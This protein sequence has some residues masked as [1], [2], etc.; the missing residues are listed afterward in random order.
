MTEK[1]LYMK[2]KMATQLIFGLF[3]LVMLNA[4]VGITSKLVHDTDADQKDGMSGMK[5]QIPFF[6]KATN[7]TSV[8]S[9][10]W[11]NR[12]YSTGDELT[13][14]FHSNRAGGQGTYDIWMSKRK[15]IDEPWDEPVNIGGP[16]NSEYEEFAVCVTPDN[17]NL[18]FSSDRPGGLG[19]YDIWLS[20]RQ[21]ENENWEDPINLG[22]MIN[23]EYNEIGPTIS[24]DGLELYFS[25]YSYT[26]PRPGTCGQEDIWVSTRTSKNAQWE[27]AKN[28]GPEVNSK[29]VDFNP[30]LSQ[31]GLLLFFVSQRDDHPGNMDIWYTCRAAT[32][33]KWKEPKN[34]GAGV[35][36]SAND[37][38]GWL[39]KDETKFY[40]GSNRPRGVGLVDLWMI[41]IDGNLEY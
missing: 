7:M 23:S 33:Q 3:M 12:P 14:Y 19:E 29:W 9:G 20:I 25:D 41:T 22:P 4:C 10:S 11:D 13:L 17:L 36:S 31:D 16:I 24:P 40:F 39:S 38:G 27:Q 8:N 35:N 15:N 18:Y 37:F 32:T 30:F 26:S 34:I 6:G 21:N 1:R 5:G 2:N 28:I